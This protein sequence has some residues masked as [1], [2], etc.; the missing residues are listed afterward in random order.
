MNAAQKIRDPG[1][2]DHGAPGA[3]HREVE[4]YRYLTILSLAGVV[5]V[6]LFAFGV[7]F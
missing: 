5:A 6:A 1:K 2:A 3:A 7:F 4:M